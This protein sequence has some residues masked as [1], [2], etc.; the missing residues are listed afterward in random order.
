[1]IARRR[2]GAGRAKI[3][4]TGAADDPGTRMST[5]LF[6]ECNVARL[7]EGADQIARL[8]HR[9]EHC[10]WIARVGP[11]IAVAQIGGREQRRVARDIYPVVAARHGA[12]AGRPEGQQA[13]R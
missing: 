3:E 5:E 6:G 2:D 1:M 8:E 9:F 10:C 11:Q 12:I 7:V 13:A 4:A